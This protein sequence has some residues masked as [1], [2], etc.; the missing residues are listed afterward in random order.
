MAINDFTYKN[1]NTIITGLKN[2]NLKEIIIPEGVLE[3]DK[4]AFCE[5]RFTKVTFPSTLK[6]I[7]YGAFD[8]CEELEELVFSDFSCLEIIDEA[9]FSNCFKLKKLNP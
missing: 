9:A 4:I 1:N 3:I 7:C 6:K 5:E 2:K 8:F